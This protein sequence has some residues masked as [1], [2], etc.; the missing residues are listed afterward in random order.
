M[1]PHRDSGNSPISS[2]PPTHHHILSAPS[3]TSFTTRAGGS[4]SRG[5]KKFDLS[6]FCGGRNRRVVPFPNQGLEGSAPMLASKPM[7]S[8]TLSGLTCTWDRADQRLVCPEGRPTPGW[9]IEPLGGSSLPTALRFLP[10]SNEPLRGSHCPSVSTSLGRKR[11]SKETEHFVP[12]CNGPTIPHRIGGTDQLIWFS[13]H[14][15]V[16][17]FPFL[18]PRQLPLH[19][20]PLCYLTLNPQ[21]I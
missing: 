5:K 18:P 8:A 14:S 21:M 12:K 13:R 2:H 15:R 16:S 19:P 1:E 9:K 11:R 20:N 3:P 17:W 6:R 7:D 10:T 4:G